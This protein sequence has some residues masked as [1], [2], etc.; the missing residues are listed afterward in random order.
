[1]VS[2]NKAQVVNDYDNDVTFFQTASQKIERTTGIPA[3]YIFTTLG[4]A[5]FSFLLLYLSLKFGDNAIDICINAKRRLYENIK[6]MPEK[7]ALE[8]FCEETKNIPCVFKIMRKRIKSIL[9]SCTVCNEGE[10]NQGFL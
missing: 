8:Y 5:G 2:C 10:N 3:K 9:M 4:V 6:K 7:K 1:M